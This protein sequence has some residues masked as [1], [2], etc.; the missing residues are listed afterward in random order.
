LGQNSSTELG[1]NKPAIR[2]E[3]PYRGFTS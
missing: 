3:R 2:P 1:V